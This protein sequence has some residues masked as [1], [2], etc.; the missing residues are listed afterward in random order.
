MRAVPEDRRARRLDRNAVLA[1]LVFVV[2]AWAYAP[3]FQYGLLDW[4][5]AEYVTENPVLAL[6][7]SR[8][9]V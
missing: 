4:D 2:A 1:A 5:D 6:G 9:A 8:A 3:S 7:V